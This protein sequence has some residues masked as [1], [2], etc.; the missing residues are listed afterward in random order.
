[1]KF[2]LIKSHSFVQVWEIWP[3]GHIV[4]KF[5]NAFTD[6]RDSEILVIR[7]DILL[8]TLWVAITLHDVM[9][10]FSVIAIL[11]FL[12]SHF[13]LLL[14]C[15]LPKW[16]SSGYNDRPLVPFAGILSLGIGDTMVSII[17]VNIYP[18]VCIYSFALNFDELNIGILP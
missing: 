2:F 4:H 5:M 16:M 6:H 12:F 17:L 14:G 8:N 11:F 3:L 7:H 1:M 18:F 10:I 9:L 15:A 13:S